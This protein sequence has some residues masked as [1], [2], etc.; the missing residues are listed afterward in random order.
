M[1]LVDI[2]NPTYYQVGDISVIDF[3]E[4]SGLNFSLGNV[5]KYIV[6]AGKKDG[7]N[8]LTALRKA[9]CYL[10]HEINKLEIAQM[11]NQKNS[12]DC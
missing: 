12:A 7:E 6:R 4:K 1:E 9:N 2:L 3:I 5:I 10:N 8:A 11:K